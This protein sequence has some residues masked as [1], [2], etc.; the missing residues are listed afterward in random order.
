MQ[1]QL[2]APKLAALD[3]FKL[4]HNYL[5]ASNEFRLQRTF[6]GYRVGTSATTLKLPTTVYRIRSFDEEVHLE[7]FNNSKHFFVIQ[8]LCS[9]IIYKS[10]I[11]YYLNFVQ[12]ISNPSPQG[13]LIILLNFKAENKVC[14]YVTH[15]FVTLFSQNVSTAH[16]VT[17][18]T[19][20]DLALAWRF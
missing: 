6:A 15:I 13:I 3:D 18:R 2:C 16:K 11:I 7:S 14:Y 12:P 20:F 8:D 9:Y 19:V 10:M 5:C 17:L 1:M 4:V